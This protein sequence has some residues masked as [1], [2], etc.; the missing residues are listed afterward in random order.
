MYNAAEGDFREEGQGVSERLAWQP[1]PR[2]N[3]KEDL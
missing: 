3:S 1:L 2:A